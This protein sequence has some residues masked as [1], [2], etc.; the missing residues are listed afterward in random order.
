MLYM[1]RTALSE[2]VIKAENCEYIIRLNSSEILKST[3]RRYACMVTSQDYITSLMG[4]LCE[5]LYK[6]LAKRQWYLYSTRCFLILLCMPIVKQFEICI[7]LTMANNEIKPYSL[8]LL[9]FCYF[10]M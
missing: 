5:A 2:S 10:S 9:S 8:L 1:Y 4:A 7:S 6:C 3:H